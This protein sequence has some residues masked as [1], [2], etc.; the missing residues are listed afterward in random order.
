M[1]SLISKLSIHTGLPEA[2]VKR[3]ASDAPVRYRQYPIKKRNGGVRLISQPA[4]EVKILQRAMMEIL[5]ST[6]PVHQSA[7]AYRS[8]LS[9]KDNAL[10]HANAGPILKMDFK[11]FFPSITIQ[12]WNK[13][14]LLNEYLTDKEDLSVAGHILF[15]RPKGSH[16]LQLA[17]GAPSSPMLS[18]AMLCEFDRI[19]SSKIADDHVIYSRYADDLTF[20]AP[21]TG[22]LNRVISQVNEAINE[23]PYPKLAVNT[24]KTRYV[25]K[26]YHRT[27]TGLTIANDGRVTIG[28]EKKR[29]LRSAVHRALNLQLT[30]RELQNL[31]GYLSFVDSIEPSF[32]DKLKRKYGSKVFSDIK[33]NISRSRPKS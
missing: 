23:I 30:D 7:T 27:V 10:R 3:I 16:R 25:T 5:I 8:G 29:E 2:V 32:V 1:S 24:E 26:K 11:D 19:I 33:R 31:A 28:R 15:H 4:R 13:F 6:F 14:C 22:F 12:A 20:S 18:N 17:I 21:R 9:I